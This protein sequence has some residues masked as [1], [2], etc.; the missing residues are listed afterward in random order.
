[1]NDQYAELYSS[2]Q[3]L[4]PSQFNIAQACLHRWAEN[5]HEGRRTA[6]YTEDELGHVDSWSYTRLSETC[7]QLANG[8]LR[9]GV[10]PG[11]RV[12]IAMG[13]RPEAVA[14]YMAIFS[15]G[16]VAV[17]LPGSLEAGGI[18]A[19]LRH[20]QARVALVDTLSGPDLLQAHMNYPELSQIVG[21]GFQHDNIIPWRTLL[22][23]QPASFKPAAVN[24][25]RP[26]LLIYENPGRKPLKG[27]LVPHGA[28]IGSLPGFVASQNWFPHM[29]GPFWSP[30]DWMSAA[31][32][33]ASLLPALYFG[34]SV[35]AALGRFS[36]ARA[37][38]ILDRYGVSHAY[39]SAVQIEQMAAETDLVARDAQLTLRAVAIDGASDRNEAMYQ[40]CE[41]NLGLAPNIVLGAAEAPL[42]IGNSQ[43]KWPAVPGSI[44]R[45]YPGHLVT[46]LDAQGLP[47]PADVVGELAVNRYDVNG[48]PDPAMFQSYWN[49]PD[50]TQARFIG[51]WWLSGMR[52]KVDRHGD[53]WYMGPVAAAIQSP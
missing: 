39:F 9:M 21:L 20:A 13:Q 30:A 3:W 12:G 2:Y 43:H 28:L 49:D 51:D 4:V 26:A 17:P 22:A 37:I 14:S 53:F 38:E 52:A 47:C 8:L 7:N 45:P 11:D 35:V 50:A 44:G 24:A 48:H 23:R 27:I 15:V 16:A 42:F 34:R 6:I 40:W 25:S 33:L 5:S 31:G 36:G 19:C 46:V 1:M 29:A 18:E 41:R 32:L 10:Q